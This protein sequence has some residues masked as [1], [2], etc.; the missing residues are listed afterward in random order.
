[1]FRWRTA[2]GGEAGGNK[3]GYDRRHTADKGVGQRENERHSQQLDRERKVGLHSLLPLPSQDS[4][5]VPSLPGLL[6]RWLSFE[7]LRDLSVNE[8]SE[9]PCVA[10]EYPHEMQGTSIAGSS[11]SAAIES[12]RTSALLASGS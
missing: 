5:R 12:G 2:E 9:C 4:G 11:G 7:G 1:M 3:D 6:Y 8:M 10:R